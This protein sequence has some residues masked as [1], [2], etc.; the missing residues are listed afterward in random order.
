MSAMHDQPGTTP[1][2]PE[3]LRADIEQTREELA[4]TAQALS[5]KLD[6]KQQARLAAGSVKERVRE[7]PAIAA[8]HWD[9]D[10]VPIAAAGATALAALLVLV[11]KDRR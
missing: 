4:Q 5:D 10:P 7:V 9:R 1:D 11:W 8:G 3:E 6:V 2:T